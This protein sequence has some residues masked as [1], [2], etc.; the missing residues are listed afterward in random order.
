M[1]CHSFKSCALLPSLLFY[2]LF[3]S[4]IQAHNVT[5]T[6]FWRD[7]QKITG[8]GKEILYNIQPFNATQHWSHWRPWGHPNSSLGVK[9]HHHALTC[10]GI[11]SSKGCHA[12]TCSG[13]CQSR[14]PRKPSCLDLPGDSISRR[15]SC[16]SLPGD[17]HPDPGTPGSQVATVLGRISFRKTHP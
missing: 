4:S 11:W 9:G 1:L 10:L 5:S 16:L 8:L 14:G 7:N 2:A 12:S 17:L 6:I 15:L 3:L 13:I